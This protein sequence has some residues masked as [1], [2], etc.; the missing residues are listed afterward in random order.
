[1]SRERI[2]TIKPE[3]FRD[4]KI[5]SLPLDARYVCIGLISR[6]DDRGRQANEQ[7]AI[8]GHVFPSGDVTVRRLTQWIVEI[9]E[10]GFVRLYAVGPFEYLWLP[11]FWKHQVI[12]KP[13]ESDYPSHPDDPYGLLPIREG[14]QAFRQDQLQEGLPDELPEFLPD[15]L[16]SPRASARSVPFRSSKEGGTGGNH[17]ADPDQ[18]PDH[19]PEGDIPRIAPLKA[20]LDRVAALKSCSTPTTRAVGLVIATYPSRDHQRHAGDFEHWWTAGKAANTGLRDVVH[21]YRNWVG[22]EQDTSPGSLMT[23]APMKSREYVDA[24]NAAAGFEP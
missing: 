1:M 19:L 16:R 23:V 9:V 11:N 10:T 2:R 5:K 6:S 12:N 4:E 22:K 21:A 8:L 18:P 14:I 7:Q 3:F 24:L 13:T 17:H 20:V 15:D